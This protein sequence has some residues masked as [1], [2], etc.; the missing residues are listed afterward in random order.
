[1]TFAHDTVRWR[2]AITDMLGIVWNKLISMAFTCLRL[3]IQLDDS[4]VIYETMG[5]NVTMANVQ[6]TLIYILLY[7]RVYGGFWTPYIHKGRGQYINWSRLAV[8]SIM[9]GN[10]LC[11]PIRIL[12]VDI[13]NLWTKSL[14]MC[15]SWWLWHTIFPR[16]NRKEHC[17]QIMVIVAVKHP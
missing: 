16:S 4:P 1:M 3:T 2:L 17:S 15:K 14:C 8:L 13:T 11:S 12:F 5:D 6:I 7:S 9:L 10:M